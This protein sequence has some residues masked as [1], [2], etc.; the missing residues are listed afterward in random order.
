LLKPSFKILLALMLGWSACKKPPVPRFERLSDAQTGVHFANTIIESDSLSVLHFEYLYNGAG[1]GVADFDRNGLPDLFFAGNQVRS[2]LYLNEGNFKFKDATA[3]SGIHTP[4]WATGVAIADVNADGWPDVYVSTIHPDRRK[5]AP[6]QL[7]IN[8]GVTDSIPVFKEVAATCGV[9]DTGYCTQAAFLD[10]DRDGDIDMYLLRNALEEYNRNEI[11]PKITDGSARSNDQLYRNDGNGPDGLPRFTNVSR[12]A[13]ITLEGWGLGVG[14]TDVNFDGWP[15][16]YCAN[17]FLSN[18][19]LWINNCDGTFSNRIAD[20]VQHQSHNSMGIDIADATNDGYPDIVT[21]DMM[22]EDNRRQKS[23]FPA[24]NHNKYALDLNLGYQPQFVRNMLQWRLP[25]AGFAETGQMAGA[26]ATDWS[27]SALFTDLDLDGWRDLWI[28]NGYKKDV[29]DLDFTTFQQNLN[30]FGTDEARRNRFAGQI[31]DL[32]G[33][34]KSNFMFRNIGPDSASGTAP[35]VFADVTRDWGLQLPSYS[36]GAAY[37][38]LD[39]D[40]DLDLV[41][42]NIDDPAFIFKNNTLEMAPPGQ[43]PHFLKINLRGAGGNTQALGSKV[44]VHCGGQIQ[45]AEQY[46]VRGYKSSVEPVLHFGLDTCRKIDSVVVVWPNG[47]RSVVHRISADQT[48]T[49]DQDAAGAVARSMPAVERPLFTPLTDP[50]YLHVENDFSDFNLQSLLPHQF[51][52]RGPTLATADVDGNG[53]DDCFVGSASGGQSALFIQASAGRFVRYAF[54]K[55]DPRMEETASIF[56]D[57]EGDGDPDLY[58]VSGGYEHPPN[59]PLYQ[60]QLY[61]NDG[62]GHFL[63]APVGTLPPE[64]SSGGCVVAADYDRDGRVDLFVGGRVTPRRYPLPPRSFLLKNNPA[65]NPAGCAFGDATP[66]ALQTPGMIAAAQLT[67]FDGDTWPDLVLAGEF[68]PLTFF[69]NNNGQFNTPILPFST[70]GTQSG[71]WNCLTAADFDRD[72]DLD[73]VAGNLGLNTRFQASATEPVGLYA[74]DYDQNG[75]ID[76]VLC[77]FIEGKEY[78]THPR[79]ALT[80]QI[81]GLKRRFLLYAD[82]GQKTIRDV[83]TAEELNGALILKNDWMATTYWE[84]R[85]NGSWGAHPLPRMA[86]L[87]PVKGAVAADFDGDGHLDLCLTG[88][89]YGAEVQSGRY[90]ALGAVVLRGDGHG[91]FEALSPAVSGIRVV[92]DARTAVVLRTGTGGQ[93]LWIGNNQGPLI[94]F[95]ID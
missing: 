19:L 75:S 36:N 69:K 39:Q 7:F 43:K 50:G 81:P 31:N 59:S 51:S 40:G 2:A 90:D 85:G 82:Y 29:T 12:A 57:A 11:R 4:H 76:P 55:A 45:Y 60:D 5:S 24:P 73:L 53:L 80:G 54:P 18:D 66:A 84:N 63:S 37:A 13:G 77:R 61:L 35:P 26:Y 38:D 48:L 86:Q 17:D 42:N 8:Q 3:Q 6:N 16:I 20:Y 27:W 83:F 72:G 91:H 25:G 92:A 79:D 28:T 32:I 71:W 65:A 64:T 21:L 44:T 70:I 68:M 56:F 62:K 34:K 23:M 52:N 41:V 67:D 9:A 93:Q 15:D 89:D 74:K 94:R 49:L 14:V 58:V 78:P 30:M 46:F 22:P 95:R 10:Y 1:V 47:R 88:N 33:V 87:G